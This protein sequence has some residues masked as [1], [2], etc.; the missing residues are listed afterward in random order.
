MSTQQDLLNE[1]L[2]RIS[3]ED[4]ISMAAE[5]SG[6]EQS[7]I[8]VNDA[9][10]YLSEYGQ[11]LDDIPYS[12]LRNTLADSGYH[13][14]PEQTMLKLYPD[15]EAIVQLAAAAIGL[16]IISQEEIANA[17]QEPRYL[18]YLLL[19]KAF[20]DINSI[21]NFVNDPDVGE[22]SQILVEIYNAYVQD[23]Q[24][25][26]GQQ[27]SLGTDT[28]SVL[29]INSDNIDRLTEDVSD[30]RLSPSMIQGRNVVQQLS[31]R[32]VVQ[33]LSPRNVVQQL[34][35][36]GVIVQQLSPTGVIVQQQPLVITQPSPQ[37]SANTSP[38]NITSQLA[39][40]TPGIIRQSPVVIAT[41]ITPQVPQGPIVG[42]FAT[43]T[44]TS[45]IQLQPSTPVVQFQ[46]AVGLT[47]A[48]S[49]RTIPQF[50]QP[51]VTTTIAP[52]IPQFQQPSTPVVQ[53]QPAVGLT[54]APSIPQFQQPSTTT[55]APS[56]PQFQQPQ[57]ETPGRFNPLNQ[58]VNQV[59]SQQIAAPQVRQQQ[60]VLPSPVSSITIPASPVSQTTPGILAYNPAALQGT[61]LQQT[62]LQLQQQQQ[63]YQ[64][65]QQ[66]QQQVP[67][68][69]VNQ[70]VPGQVVPGLF[71]NASR[72]DLRNYVNRNLAN[73]FN[74]KVGQKKSDAIDVI[75][76]L[77]NSQFGPQLLATYPITF[78]LNAVNQTGKRT[79]TR[80]AYVPR[81][82]RSTI[83]TSPQRTLA[84]NQLPVQQTTRA[85]PA[86][87]LYYTTNEI[88]EIQQLRR[89]LS[90]MLL[91]TLRGI[92]NNVKDG[93]RRPVRSTNDAV[94]TILGLVKS[95]IYTLEQFGIQTPVGGIPASTVPGQLQQLGA[96]VTPSANVIP[97]ELMPYYNA[98]ASAD[99]N[100][101]ANALGMRIPD[102]IQDEAQRK[103]YIIKNLADYIWIIRNAGKFQPITK[104]TLQTLTDPKSYLQ[105]L[106]DIQIFDLIEA[107]VPYM[108]RQQLVDS[109]AKLARNVG[110]F[111]PLK[112]SCDNT[113]LTDGTP[114]SNT[115]ITLI[116]I[117]TLNNYTCYTI[118]DIAA[119]VTKDNSGSV[120]I[121]LP[122]GTY[123]DNV[124][125][126]LLY[127]LSGM[128]T[129]TLPIKNAIDSALGYA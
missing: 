1:F 125:L 113:L 53:F 20:P 27:S 18:A 5:I 64:F 94:E 48:P 32:N 21:N 41:S 82:E 7:S 114:T 81:V 129:A 54:V 122:D 116:A 128:Y 87:Q 34:S 66:Q 3:P 61:G 12:S 92:I 33:Q 115:N 101:V 30:I 14:Y 105:N 45:P 124:N 63:A 109:A 69:S 28:S 80:Q 22:I 36:T 73:H 86:N 77:L 79:P 70:I 99:S 2:S 6:Q 98:V 117:G 44:V 71:E 24:N 35:P 31:P 49:P 97:P 51:V 78:N 15:P 55:I 59:L 88:P 56:I 111:I 112:R 93:Q 39:P 100:Y 107:Y 106:T 96:A 83:Y 102:Q 16:G 26:I 95:G 10:R 29:S 84:N 67:Q 4:V 108:S 58:P 17:S 90:N 110:V 120:I 76:E 62:G 126:S 119:G 89:L 47:V 52:S 127:D 72:D 121:Q 40:S 60:T 46:P 68:I 104:A 13:L 85:S 43:Q 19:S 11:N 118:N 42:Q 25:F 38:I 65:Q 9:I 8:G 103:D 74:V 37:S 123:L 91:N 50:Q 57:V 23:Y 75:V